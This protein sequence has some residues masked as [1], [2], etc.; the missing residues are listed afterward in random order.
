VFSFFGLFTFLLEPNNLN[1][2]L[3]TFFLLYGGD[4]PSILLQQAH[5]WKPNAFVLVALSFILSEHLTST[6]Y[7]SPIAKIV[8]GII[9][10][11]C[12]EK[13]SV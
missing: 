8:E 2:K 1:F 3:E 4:L 5:C 12:K 13:G 7:S 9:V 6:F 10:Q 11:A